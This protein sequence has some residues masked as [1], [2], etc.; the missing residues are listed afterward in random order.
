MALLTCAYDLTR[1]L[2]QTV[3]GGPMDLADVVVRAPLVDSPRV[4]NMAGS[5]VLQGDGVFT[6]HAHT[7]NAVRRHDPDEVIRASDLR[8]QPLRPLLGMEILIPEHVERRLLQI[9]DDLAHF[10]LVFAGIGDEHSH[11]ILLLRGPT[12]LG[13]RQ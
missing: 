13:A 9:T 10:E 7:V 4:E 8:L 5:A 1:E 2:G 11:F 6:I 3:Y 12:T